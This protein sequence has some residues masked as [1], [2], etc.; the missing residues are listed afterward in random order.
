[1]ILLLNFKSERI[2]VMKGFDRPLFLTKCC[3][4][5]R[6]SIIGR[7]RPL[8]QLIQHPKVLNKK[9]LAGILSKHLATL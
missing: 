8:K 3:I 2:Y 9:M 6:N 7:F 5:A 4:S 1:M